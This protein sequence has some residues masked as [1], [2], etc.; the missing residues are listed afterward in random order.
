MTKRRGAIA[1]DRFTKAL[2]DL[3]AA[4]LR[5][6]CS[7]PDTAHLWLSEYPE[8]RT[9]AVRLCE[10]CPVIM[11]C[12]SAAVARDERWGV[13]GGVDRSPRRGAVA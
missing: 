13:W 1:S 6:H 12:W 9:Q 8:D 2:I 3:A 10:G 11:E 5:T 7:D 4:E